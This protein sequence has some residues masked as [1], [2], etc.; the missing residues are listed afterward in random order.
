MAIQRYVQIPGLTQK[1]TQLS[2]QDVAK[3]GSANGLK[4]G[5]DKFMDTGPTGSY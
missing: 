3:A 1:K 5:L 2:L 4:K